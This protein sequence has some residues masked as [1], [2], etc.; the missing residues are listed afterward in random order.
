MFD[1]LGWTDSLPDVKRLACVLL[2]DRRGWVLLQERD[3]GAPIAPDKWGMPGGHVEPGEVFEDA[4]YRELLEETGLDLARGT[5]ELWRQEQFESVDGDGPHSYRV[6]VA[7]ADLR[8]EDI[9]VGEG[10]Q[11]VFVDPDE[12][13]G[14]DKSDSCAHF[15]AEFL[16]SP[17]YAR[18]SGGPASG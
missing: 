10:R 2:V 14:L 4:A 5:L 7:A 13:P 16:E 1:G 6:Y 8:D 18:L 3:S 9:V 11:I 15:V 17:E 12:V